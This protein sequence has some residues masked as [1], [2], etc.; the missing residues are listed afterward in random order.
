GISDKGGSQATVTS[1]VMVSDAALTASGDSI[2][3]TEGASFAG[4]VAT[5]SDA[6]RN[7]ALSDYTAMI[8]WGDGQSSTGT[9]SLGAG[10]T[11]AVSGNHTYADEGSYTVSV[12]IA[13]AGG[14]SIS[15]T[16]SATV[17]DAALNAQGASINATEGAAFSGAVVATFNDANLSAAAG[18]FTATIS[19]GDGGSSLGTVTANGGGLF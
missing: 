14:A 3:A 7:G 19:W 2:S 6:D 8:T 1:E 13:D 4:Q 15:T 10:G 9:I 17:G 18:D 12:Q 11:F 16:G 5:F